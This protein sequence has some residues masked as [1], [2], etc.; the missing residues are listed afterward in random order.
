MVLEKTLESPLD[1][2]EIKPVHPKGNQSWIFIGRTDAE[3]E[4]P[5]LWPLMQRTDSLEKT[6]MLGKI[7]GVR[8][9][10]QQRMRWLDG[11]TY[12][13]DMSLSK[14]RELV[15]DREAWRAA[16]HGVAMSWT[17]LSNWA[18]L[19][20]TEQKII[21]HNIHHLKVNFKK[22]RISKTWQGHHRIY[23][24]S[25][26]SLSRVWLFLTPWT[27]ACQASLSSTNSLSSLK[28][29]SIESVMPS[30]YLI[31]CCPLLLL[32]SILPSIW[33]FSNES[34]F[35][36]RWP[37]YWS[38]SFS[39]I[40]SNEYSGP[41]SF[42]MDWLDLLAVQGTL[43]SLQHHS[44]KASILWCSPFFIVQLLHPYMTI[45]K[46]IPSTIWTFVGKVM[47]LFFNMF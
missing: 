27:A 21:N 43:K 34:G 29:K 6:L 4:A 40:L 45:G 26:Q 13:M 16:V 14:L 25:V 5:I 46:P 17:H 3:V 7:E 20:W 10:G 11:I 12:S 39:I 1:C 9:R 18:E 2:K 24:S 33:V 19:N 28:L 35:L 32:P 44:S 22:L 37:K 15:L 31:L 47:S 8:R 30:N 42:R 36:I 23:F 38:F 41:I